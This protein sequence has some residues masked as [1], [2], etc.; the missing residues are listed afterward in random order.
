MDGA[1]TPT[2]KRPKASGTRRRAPRR[3]PQERREE[4]LDAAMALIVRDGYRAATMTAVAR[5]LHLTKPVVY[6]VFPNFK[7]LGDALI[8]R[9]QLR[10][11]AQI[12][13][14]L[15]TAVRP[16]LAPADVMPAALGAFLRSVTENPEPWRLV[17]MPG[18]ALPSG[19]ARRVRDGRRWAV[20][21]CMRLCEQALATTRGD[22][23]QVDLEALAEGII[24]SVER[25]A[26]LLLADPE[27]WTP[28]RLET[29][30]KSDLLWRPSISALAVAP[31]RTED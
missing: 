18:G 24:A 20:E 8:E 29:F 17:L 11:L 15:T 1:A 23:S 10:C 7:A 13:D 19:I 6:A 25:Y 9:E 26:Q 2:P 22:G 4:V 30:A 5:E 31:G 3:P 27:K 12:R 28:E 14:A 21:G 16:D